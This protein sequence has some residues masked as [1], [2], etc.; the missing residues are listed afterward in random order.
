[1]NLLIRFFLRRLHGAGVS[2][3]GAAPPPGAAHHLAVTLAVNTDRSPVTA[4]H[5][6]D[7]AAWTGALVRRWSTGS[8]VM[9]G[10]HPSAEPSTSGLRNAAHRYSP[11]LTSTSSRTKRASNTIRCGSRRYWSPGAQ[12]LQG[13]RP[14][15]RSGNGLP[16]HGWRKRRGWRALL[17]C[18]TRRLVAST[19][20][21]PTCPA[22][23]PLSSLCPSSPA[24]DVQP[25]VPILQRPTVCTGYPGKNDSIV[26]RLAVLSALT[27]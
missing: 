16:Q 1:M 5:R 6:H 2:G 7:W 13:R 10:I 3:P 21:A 27:T 8:R 26:A 17:S 24:A 15:I 11:P 22:L 25:A 12:P 14:A 23:A 20:F 4:A 18:S 9:A 19:R